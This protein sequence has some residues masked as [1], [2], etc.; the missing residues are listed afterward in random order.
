MLDLDN[1]DG[2]REWRVCVDLEVCFYDARQ[3]DFL[4]PFG[5][6]VNGFCEGEINHSS[7]IKLARVL[8]F[9]DVVIATRQP[10]VPQFGKH[11]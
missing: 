7:A 8:P 11:I 6:W 4:S 9:W 5:Q 1:G 3:V 10:F 2:L